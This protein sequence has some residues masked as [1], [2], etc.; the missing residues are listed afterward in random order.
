MK[1]F[2]YYLLFVSHASF[3]QTNYI[4]VVKKDLIKKW[5]T[6][7]EVGKIID[8]KKDL[9]IYEKEGISSLIVYRFSFAK[10]LVGDLNKDG[11]SEHLIIVEEEGGG[12]GGNVGSTLNYVVYDKGKNIFIIKQLNEIV[13]PPKNDDGFYFDIEEIKD[14]FLFGTLNVCIR[15]GQTKYDDEWKEIKAKCRLIDDKLQLVY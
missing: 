6:K 2:F 13:N 5:K 11:K 12:A 10:K 15:R 3:S 4:E 9:Y 1:R 8:Q 14:G 7:N